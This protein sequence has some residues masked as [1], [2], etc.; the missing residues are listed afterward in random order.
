MNPLAVEGIESGPARSSNW[1][2]W[3]LASR[4]EI[5]STIVSPLAC[6]GMYRHRPDPIGGRYGFAAGRTFLKWR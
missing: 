2:C 6:G 5:D 1:I 3:T 4:T